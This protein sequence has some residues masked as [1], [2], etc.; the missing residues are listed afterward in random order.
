M[1]VAVAVFE[2]PVCEFAVALT[3]LD[4]EVLPEELLDSLV[5]VDPPAFWP[6][7]KI[8]AKLKVFLS[9]KAL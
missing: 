7:E 9:V 5:E 1:A 3:V 4:A 2:P 8:F 6:K